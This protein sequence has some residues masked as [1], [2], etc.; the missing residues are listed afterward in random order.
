MLSGWLLAIILL[1]GVGFLFFSLSRLHWAYT[2]ALIV[3]YNPFFVYHF[4]LMDWWEGGRL[5]A[6]TSVG[7]LAVLAMALFMRR[8][9]SEQLLRRVHTPMDRWLAIFAIFLLTGI[10]VGLYA[11]NDFRLILADLFPLCEFYCFFLLTTII[12]SERDHARNMMLTLLTTGAVSALALVLLYFSRG[13]LFQAQWIVPRLI[14][15][16]PV[17]LFPCAV[18]VYLHAP[19]RRL[20][21]YLFLCSSIFL[22][23]ILVGFWRVQWIAAIISTVFVLWAS[24][25]KRVLTYRYFVLLGGVFV[26]TL[27]LAETGFSSMEAS[28]SATALI[29]ARTGEGLPDVERHGRVAEAR[30]L[31]ATIKKSPTLGRGLG[32]TF[33][34]E[35]HGAFLRAL[36][37]GSSHN[38]YLSV[39]AEM[40]LPALAVLLVIGSM[41]LKSGL[42]RVRG[43]QTGLD[44]G[45]AIG[46]LGTWVA[47]SITFMAQAP[48]L[49]FPLLAYL[50]TQGALIFVLSD[51]APT[52]R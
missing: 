46:C 16:M 41:L 50:A 28:P 48:V 35:A 9:V 5:R 44:R 31:W 4:L 25:T 33:S 34:T 26:L 42:A 38:F 10:V 49:H 12:F 8:A 20:R 37:L 19:T 39:A 3:L 40:G 23:S 30:D 11:G 15:F 51:H 18:G 7:L 14:D 27:I 43:M 29:R 21:M 45:I 32:G 22:L 47:A 6:A 24:K 52:V 17:L 13:H 36:P 1:G 2:S